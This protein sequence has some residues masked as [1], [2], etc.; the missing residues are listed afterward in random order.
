[1][2]LPT[3]I[4]SNDI[5]HD[6]AALRQRA[7]SQGYLFFP[8]LIDPAE[9]MQIRG[10]IASILQQVGWIEADTDSLLAITG[11]QAA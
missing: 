8:A 5:R 2:T 3:L 4:K 9:I 10:K 11:H 7:D 1:M 6:G